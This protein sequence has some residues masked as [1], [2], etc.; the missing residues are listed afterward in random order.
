MAGKPELLVPKKEKLAYDYGVEIGRY[1]QHRGYGGD[2]DLNK[3]RAW[4]TRVKNSRSYAQGNQSTWKYKQAFNATGDNSPVNLD[5]SPYPVGPKF[6]HSIVE[7]CIDEFHYEIDAIDKTSR[8]EKESVKDR[9]IEN[10]MDKDFIQGFEK[11]FDVKIPESQLIPEDM[12]DVQMALTMD[13]RSSIETAVRQVLEAIMNLNE[14]PEEV[15]YQ[16]GYDMVVAGKAVGETD[17]SPTEGIEMR[18]VDVENFASSE[19]N[20]VRGKDPEWGSELKYYSIG[21]VL[22]MAKN[23]NIQDRNIKEIATKFRSRYNNGNLDIDWNDDYGRDTYHYDGRYDHLTVPVI[24]FHYK[25]VCYDKLAT[26]KGPYG[27]RVKRKNDQYDSDDVKIDYDY[28]ETILSGYYIAGTDF[29]FNYGEK[30]NLIRPNNS[31]HKVENPYKVYIPQYYN[32]TYKSLMEMIIPN[33]DAINKAHLKMQQVLIRSH[34]EVTV[35]D[36]SAWAEMA[37]GEKEYDHLDL[38]DIYDATGIIYKKGTDEQGNPIQDPVRSYNNAVP[39]EPFIN[40]I[41]FHFQQIREIMGF[42]PAREGQV[43]EKQLIGTTEIALDKAANATRYITKGVQNIS[44]KMIESAVWLVQSIPK[45]SDIL[46]RYAEMIGD[47]DMQIIRSMEDMPMRQFGVFVH[48][49]VDNEEKLNFN[50][51]IE[52]SLTQKEITIEDAAKAR[53]I[54]KS[55]SPDVAYE[56]LAYRR[57][58]R[59]KEIEQQQ[60]AMEQQKSQLKMQ[61]EQ[62]KAEVQKVEETVRG[63]Y[64]VKEEQIRA[65]R[66]L[67]KIDLEYARRSELSRQEFLQNFQIKK[68]EVTGKMEVDEMKEEGKSERSTQ[69]TKEKLKADEQKIELKEGKRKTANLDEID[70][71]GKFSELAKQMTK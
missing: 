33:I 67:Q 6:V 20:N 49:K 36:Y 17:L 14:F 4:R 16:L 12:E 71:D 27:K 22:R 55:L 25:T 68:M 3:N 52:R 18:Y 30:E 62:A 1:I 7:D 41:N 8:S 35:I 28:Y 26:K 61:E 9:L 39:I 59:Q 66:D 43:Q 42:P 24:K 40:T 11:L 15:R 37:L 23:T 29:I 64:D 69:E 54:A 65:Q 70:Q 2:D 31:L 50:R 63:E 47:Y 32:H 5:F 21:D 56:Y 34:P 44:K 38:Q 48:M 58:K 57:K 13:Y 60:M 51:D 45:D 19:T 53:G 10:L 46:K